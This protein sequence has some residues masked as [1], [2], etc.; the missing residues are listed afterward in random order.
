ML[1][2]G[3]LLMAVSNYHEYGERIGKA[4]KVLLQSFKEVKGLAKFHFTNV[5]YTHTEQKEKQRDDK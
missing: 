5:K 2:T 4:E 3:K 1:L